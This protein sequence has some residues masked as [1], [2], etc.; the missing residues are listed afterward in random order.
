MIKT[1]P[2][3]LNIDVALLSDT[4]INC[5]FYD[6]DAFSLIKQLVQ[7][8]LG[9]TQSNKDSSCVIKRKSKR[10]IKAKRPTSFILYE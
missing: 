1:K 2:E 4:N 3:E 5:L 7:T 10:E 8:K 6:E 9:L